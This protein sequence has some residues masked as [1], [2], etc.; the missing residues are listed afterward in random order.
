M[1][2]V[3]VF[4]SQSHQSCPQ[5]VTWDI[6]DMLYLKVTKRHRHHDA[7]AIQELFI[8]IKTLTPAAHYLLTKGLAKSWHILWF[9][10]DDDKREIRSPFQSTISSVEGKVWVEWFHHYLQHLHLHHSQWGTLLCVLVHGLLHS[11]AP[12]AP[13]D[14]VIHTT[15]NSISRA[16]T[17]DYETLQS[18][19]TQLDSWC[20]NIKNTRFCRLWSKKSTFQYMVQ[21][22]QNTRLYAL[23]SKKFTTQYMV[24]KHQNMRL[25]RVRNPPL[26]AWC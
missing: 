10:P 9:S 12:S 1:N 5:S 20:K 24:K 21:K 17:L 11:A 25:Y 4:T 16:I 19:T 14:P 15:H 22:H 18:K 13:L 2:I 23:W 6:L 3:Q 7:W 26:N 8:Y